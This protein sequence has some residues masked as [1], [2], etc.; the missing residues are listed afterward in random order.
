MR[1]RVLRGRTGPST[2]TVHANRLVTRGEASTSIRTHVPKVPV[3]KVH[4]NVGTIGHVDH[5]KTTLTAAI[6]LVTAA[7]CGGPGSDGF[8]SDHVGTDFDQIDKPPR[9]AV[10]ASPSRRPT[11]T[12]LGT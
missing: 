11:P 7:L 5:G 12:T 4:V 9:S 6:S 10:V 2:I 3:P 1:P 8:G